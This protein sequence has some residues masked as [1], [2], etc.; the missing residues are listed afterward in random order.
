[1]DWNCHSWKS[2][3][4]L[5]RED[6][7]EI[8]TQRITSLSFPCDRW[9]CWCHDNIDFFVCLSEIITD[10]FSDCGCFFVVGIIKTA[11]KYKWTR[12]RTS[13]YFCSESFF[14]IHRNIVSSVCH[15]AISYPVKSSHIGRNFCR[16]DHIVYRYS[17]LVCGSEI[18]MISAPSD[19]AVR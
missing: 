9:G 16:T 15:M 6:I 19:R 18:S 5:N 17:M 10:E 7:F 1:M 3:E 12:H 2:C 14:T 8:E 13:F 4:M 11:R